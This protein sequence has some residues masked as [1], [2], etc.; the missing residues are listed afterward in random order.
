MAGADELDDSGNWFPGDYHGFGTYQG[1][2]NTEDA[3]H[4]GGIRS[5]RWT[6]G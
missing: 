4:P 6:G 2:V 3:I 5:P 1:M